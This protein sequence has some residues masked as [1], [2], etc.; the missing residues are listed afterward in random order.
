MVTDIQEHF[1]QSESRACRLIGM[2]RSSFRYRPKPD[3][4]TGLALRMRTLAEHKPRYG[5]RRLHVLLRKEGLVVN[6]KRTERLYRQENLAIRTKPRKKLP[7]TVRAP[8]PTPSAMNECWAV[9]FVRDATAYG[10]TFRCFSVLD[11]YARECL[12]IHVDTSILSRV[13]IDVL[14]RCIEKRG[15]PSRMTVDNGPEFT[16]RSFLSWAQREKIRIIHIAPGKPMQNAFI[17]S[18]QGKFRD[19]CLNLHWFRSLP[20]ARERVEEFRITHNTE[21][22]HSSLGGL[23]PREF[24]QRMVV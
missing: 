13:V 23:T 19:E 9:D 3:T 11:V 20:E 1:G 8:L 24:A 2:H 21:R 18:F 4:D 12:A 14:G 17:E 15:K 22:P 16:S 6:H 10:R 5:V 7:V